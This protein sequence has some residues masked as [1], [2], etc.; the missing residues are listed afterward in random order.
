MSSLDGDEGGCSGPLHGGTAIATLDSVDGGVTDNGNNSETEPAGASAAPSVTEPLADSAECRGSAESEEEKQLVAP[1]AQLHVAGAATAAVHDSDCG[2]ERACDG[3]GGAS[4]DLEA[5]VSGVGASVPSTHAGAA[6][7]SGT[8]GLHAHAHALATTRWDVALVAVDDE[9]ALTGVP[10]SAFCGCNGCSVSDH[11]FDTATVVG[12]LWLF[13]C[14][15]Y[16]QSAR[17]QQQH[18]LCLKH[19]HWHRVHACEGDM[20]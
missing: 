13:Q 2:C 8:P 3:V 1:F 19:Q 5:G 6:A 20:W 7:R 12:R 16:G 18:D 17:S 14:P 9:G 15:G 10:G 11:I 4:N